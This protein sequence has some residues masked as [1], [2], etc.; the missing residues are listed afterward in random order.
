M[1]PSWLSLSC[2][3]SSWPAYLSPKCWPICAVLPFS[4]K[5][6]SLTQLPS[7]AVSTIS[8]GAKAPT[9]V[10]KH[11]RGFSESNLNRIYS[12]ILSLRVL[13][14]RGMHQ[15]YVSEQE[16]LVKTCCLWAWPYSRGSLVLTPHTSG[17]VYGVE[18]LVRSTHSTLPV[19]TRW[20]LLNLEA[21]EGV[22]LTVCRTEFCCTKTS[23]TSIF[24]RP[25]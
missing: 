15:N 12:I 6:S 3:L 8:P 13:L 22:T 10:S 2:S 5:L 19:G 21:D 24:P 7:S 23:R 4:Y 18:N 16:E 9:I 25:L 20:W 17:R 1:A 11:T 14:D